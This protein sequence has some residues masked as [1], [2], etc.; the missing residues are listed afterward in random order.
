MRADLKTE[1][2]KRKDDFIK[3][4][5]KNSAD[6]S[7]LWRIFDSIGLTS[8]TYASPL[9]F[10]SA[11]EINI[12]FSNINMSSPSCA[13]LPLFSHLINLDTTF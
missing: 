5:L 4:R 12:F 11:T 2:R 13:I 3:N 7:T 1:V 6:T 9:Q 8:T 10:F